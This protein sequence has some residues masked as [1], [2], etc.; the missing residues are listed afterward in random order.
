MIINYL[1]LL[2]FDRLCLTM[3]AWLQQKI[4]KAHTLSLRV[5]IVVGNLGLSAWPALGQ[6]GGTLP[7]GWGRAEWPFSSSSEQKKVI[8]KKKL[9][10]TRRNHR[11]S[12]GEFWP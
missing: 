11:L 6:A 4:W 7:S 3:I 1:N 2:G 9:H 12:Q 10:L 5:S 8:M